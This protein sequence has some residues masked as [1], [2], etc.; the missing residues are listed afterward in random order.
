MSTVTRFA[1]SPTGRIHIGNARTALFNWLIA[2]REGGRF[3]VRVEDTDSA[4]TVPGGADAVLGDLAWLGLDPAERP[5]FQSQRRGGHEAALMQL[6]DAGQLYPCFCSEATLK[7]QRR[8]QQEAGKPPRY[9]GTC[10]ALSAADAARRVAAGE[11]HTL[12][13]RVPSARTVAFTD[14]VHGELQFSSSDIGDFVVCRTDGT[15][16]FFFANALDDTDAGVTLVLR[17]EDHL[18]NTP[19]QLLL[20]EALGRPAPEYGHLPLVHDTGGGKLSK[21][22]G[23]LSV[24]ALREMGFHPLAVANYLARLGGHVDGLEALGLD[25]LAA[26]FDTGHFARASAAFDEM[27]LRHWQRKVLDASPPEILWD[28][29]GAAVHERVPA[30]A[31]A[32]FITLVRPNVLFPGDALDWAFVVFDDDPAPHKEAVTLLQGTD[33]ALFRGALD[34]YHE[35]VAWQELVDA[36]RNASGSRGPALFKPLRAALTGRLDGPDLAGLFAMLAPQRV[37]TRLERA[38]SLSAGARP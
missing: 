25:T 17:G 5:W 34:C 18:S 26:A 23:A 15:P 16:A 27:Q 37:R 10:A 31:Q 28:W 33:A 38:V 36:A 14:R 8:A 32:A 19:R 35:G 3:L 7:M 1:P 30:D 24:S 29:F 13:F 9:L 6:R 20:L 4:R 11:A 2:R 12:R 22:S 21:R